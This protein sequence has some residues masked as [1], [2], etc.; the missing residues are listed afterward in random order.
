M[1]DI[2]DMI[3]VNIWN[4]HPSHEETAFLIVDSRQSC[5]QRMEMVI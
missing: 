3:A 2:A 1:I 5:E 4:L